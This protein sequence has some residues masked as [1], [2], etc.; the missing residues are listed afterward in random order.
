MY[1][2]KLPFQADTNKLYDL[3][4]A[5]LPVETAF[6]TYKKATIIAMTFGHSGTKNNPKSSRSTMNRTRLDDL[7]LL[8]IEI[9]LPNC[10]IGYQT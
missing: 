7:A 2:E 6:P 8:H 9:F 5:L 3:L 1:L 10:G 4:E